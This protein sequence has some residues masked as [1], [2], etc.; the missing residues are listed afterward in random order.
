MGNLAI[1]KML[2]DLVDFVAYDKGTL[3][4][5]ANAGTKQ[6]CFAFLASINNIVTSTVIQFYKVSI[7]TMCQYLELTFCIIA[8]KQVDCFNT[9]R[10]LHP[11][12]PHHHPNL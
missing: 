7:H 3:L 2:R 6:G 9:I 8:R 4:L 10:E 11:H 1:T 12:F 5:F